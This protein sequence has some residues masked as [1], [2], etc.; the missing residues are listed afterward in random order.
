MAIASKFLLAIGRKH[1]FNPVAIGVAVAAL[2]LDQPATW[3]VGGNLTLLPFVLVG[4]LLIVRK[5]QRFDLVGA[6][7]LANLAA[8]LAMTPLAMSGKA[9]TQTLL[10]SPLLFAGFVMLTEP[11]TAPHAKMAAPRLRRDRRRA[12]L[13]RTSTSAGSTSRRKSR[14]SS[15][16]SS[17]SR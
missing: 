2:L 16:T 8:T 6:Y 12:V 1:I 10:S 3:W 4:G 5:L 17:P 13:A 11:L 9:L 15:A 14:F 7:V